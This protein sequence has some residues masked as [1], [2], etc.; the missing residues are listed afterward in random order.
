MKTYLSKNKESKI[1][2][3]RVW[4]IIM[5]ILGILL[6]IVVLAEEGEVTEKTTVVKEGSL[7]NTF[8]LENKIKIL[9]TSVQPLHCVERRRIVKTSKKK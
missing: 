7:V 3:K 1:R 5:V 8:K 2:E 4:T 9:E 6:T